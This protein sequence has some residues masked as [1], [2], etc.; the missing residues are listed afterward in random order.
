VFNSF[1]VPAF[2]KF[3]C[4]PALDAQL[5]EAGLPALHLSGSGSAC[6]CL[7]DAADGARASTLAETALGMGGFT[8]QTFI[9]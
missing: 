9:R 6:Y 3:L 2:A 1:Q 5:R 8:A 4:Y 7:V